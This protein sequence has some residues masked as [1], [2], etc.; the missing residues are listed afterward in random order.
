LFRAAALRS[1]GGWVV[2]GRS[3]RSGG[4]LR[5]CGCS[6]PPVASRSAH[7]PVRLDAAPSRGHRGPAAPVLT[8]RKK[9]FATPRRAEMRSAISTASLYSSNCVLEGSGMAP[10]ARTR[11]PLGLSLV[12]NLTRHV[13]ATER[14]V[15]VVVLNDVADLLRLAPRPAAALLAD[16]G[17]NHA[18][19][20]GRHELVRPGEPPLGQL[21]GSQSIFSPASIM[22]A[23]CR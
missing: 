21:R 12:V 9:L 7:R 13:L 11:E 1:G 23:T 4:S 19:A 3:R 6:P 15:R 17:L 8:V 10:S 2:L 20:P 18:L 22:G 14:P 16:V 5:C